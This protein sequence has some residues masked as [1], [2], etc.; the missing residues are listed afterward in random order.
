[1]FPSIDYSDQS[2][3]TE[4]TRKNSNEKN[5]CCQGKGINEVELHEGHPRGDGRQ[6]Q[7]PVLGDEGH[8]ACEE[9]TGREGTI[10]E[11]AGNVLSVRSKAKYCG[12]SP[13]K[14]RILEH[15]LQSLFKFA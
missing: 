11:L 15:C 13:P 7:R 10:P 12:F 1:M 4:E 9:L 6:R 2:A 3:K 5:E 14:P 8:M